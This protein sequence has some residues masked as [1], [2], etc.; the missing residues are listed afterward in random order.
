MSR[1]RTHTI[2][3]APAGSRPLLQ[4]LIKSSPTGRFLNV[5]AE[6]AHSPAVLA[7]YASLRAVIAEHGTLDPKAAWALN[8]TTAGAVGNA[9]MIGIATRFAR[10]NGWTDTQI[11]ALRTG[12][13]IGD[14]KIDTLTGVVR[15]AAAK[16]GSVTDTTWNAALQAGWS[17]Q[18]LTE[19]FAYLGLTVFTGYF[20]NYAQTEMDAL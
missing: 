7:A 10:A 15:E 1:I 13:P 20:L 5:H 17:A 4:S 11:A 9:Y 19:A 14:T 8:L 2:E 6:M 3:D 16:S 12:T 18:Q